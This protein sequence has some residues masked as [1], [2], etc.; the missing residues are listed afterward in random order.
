MGILAVTT[1]ILGGV[2]TIMGIV[3]AA[4]TEPLVGAGFGQTFWFSLAVIFVLATIASLL[5]LSRYE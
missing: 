4:L 5:A 1:F 3:N 2:C